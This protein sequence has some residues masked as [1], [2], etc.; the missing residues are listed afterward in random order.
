[1][2]P[3]KQT[4]KEI[5]W[6]WAENWNDLDIEKVVEELR[7]IAAPEMLEAIKMVAAQ[8]NR[9]VVPIDWAKLDKALA[10]AEGK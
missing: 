4:I 8:I 2:P 5:L 3:E 10:A 9:E 7:N 6:D 1:M